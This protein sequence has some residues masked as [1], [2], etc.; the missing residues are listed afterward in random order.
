[1]RK[2]NFIKSPKTFFKK[3][4]IESKKEPKEMEKWKMTYAIP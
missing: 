4:K 2:N 1:M 3:N